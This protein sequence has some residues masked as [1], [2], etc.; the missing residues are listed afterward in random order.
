[1]GNLTIAIPLGWRNDRWKQNVMERQSPR[2]GLGQKTLGFTPTTETSAH[3]R[4]S[5]NN[6]PAD[7]VKNAVYAETLYD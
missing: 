6:Q 2:P 1:M 4:I 7:I 5:D 3:K